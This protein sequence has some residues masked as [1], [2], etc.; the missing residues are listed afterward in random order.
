MPSYHTLGKIPH[1]R[2]TQFR[3]PDGTLYAE[4]LVSTE[5]FSSAYSLIY[6]AHPPTMVKELGEPYSV[7]PKIVREKHLKHTSLIGFNIKSE[8]DYLQS[9]KPVLVNSDLHISLAA[10]RKSMTDYFY[11]N[12]QA[13]EVVFIHEGTGT[14]KTGFGNIKFAYGD[15]P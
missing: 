6:H 13:D 9:R 1:K 5:G 10:P 15:Y 8:D 14:L 11:K 12:S 2:H 4:E 3:K 7:E